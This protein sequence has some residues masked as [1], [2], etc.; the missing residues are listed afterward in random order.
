MSATLRIIHPTQVTPKPW[1][2]GGG[3]T[4]TLLAWPDPQR[5]QLR[6]SVADVEAGGPFSV[7]P[8]IDRWFA[9]LDGDGV[10]LTTAGRAPV[11]VRPADDAMHEFPGDAATECELLGG[12]TGDLNVMRRR[13]EAT[14]TITSLRGSVS[15]RSQAEG[16]GCFV[17][18]P[19][20]LA[21]DRE[22]WVALPRHAL[23]WLDNPARES[24]TWCVSSP[25]PRGWWIEVNRINADADQAD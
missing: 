13:R 25:A 9:V 5:W 16:L 3:R 6:I 21:T 11:V 17:D 20:E 18:E 19:V 23:A 14:V 10:R 7:F 15:V 12:A 2:N 4:R 8:G 22:P 24:V 1:A